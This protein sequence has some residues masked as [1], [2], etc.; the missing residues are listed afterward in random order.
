M[1]DRDYINII[2]ELVK[3]IPLDDFIQRRYVRGQSVS[4]AE[5][6]ILLRQAMNAVRY[7][8]SRNMVHR[9][10]KPANIIVVG[11]ETGN[12]NDLN[13]KIIDFGLSKVTKRRKKEFK[14]DTFCGSLHFMAPEI[15]SEDANSK[16]YDQKC[17]IWSL[18][19]IAFYLLSGQLPFNGASELALK[20]KILT[21]DYEYEGPAWNQVS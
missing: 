20:K 16:G 9:D 2:M 15:F 18:G 19:V 17:D 5:S 4:E 6:Q 7:L 21:C 1:Y 3:G 8:H 10:L 14:M 12:L 11:S 13:L